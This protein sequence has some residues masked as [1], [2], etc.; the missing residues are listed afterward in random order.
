MAGDFQLLV[1]QGPLSLSRLNPG[2]N[3]SNL[4]LLQNIPGSDKYGHLRVSS[5]YKPIQTGS[6]IS[7][8]LGSR[9]HLPSLLLG[10][11]K[12]YIHGTLATGPCLLWIHDLSWWLSG[13]QH[14]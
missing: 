4:D 1:L 13:I 12:V 11:K 5:E 6:D 2:S 14:T 8:A 9:L 3:Y 7:T 10:L